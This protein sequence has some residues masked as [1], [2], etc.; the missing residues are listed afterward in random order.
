MAPKRKKLRVVPARKSAPTAD[1]RR[2]VIGAEPEEVLEID[3]EESEEEE[4]VQDIEDQV[5][6]RL[7][8]KSIDAI[9]PKFNIHALETNVYLSQK[10]GMN[11]THGGS[12]HA[13]LRNH[14]GDLV[15]FNEPKN[16]YAKKLIGYVL[17]AFT[18]WA[19]ENGS[20][21][22]PGETLTKRVVCEEWEY[23]CRVMDVPYVKPITRVQT[24]IYNF[25]AGFCNG[26][27]YNHRIRGFACI[28]MEI[29]AGLNKKPLNEMEAFQKSCDILWANEVKQ[30]TRK[31]PDVGW[32]LVL[33]KLL[34][35]HFAQNDLPEIP[36]GTT[37]A[38]AKKARKKQNK[39]DETQWLEGQK[40][41][42]DK[43]PEVVRK[44]KELI[45]EYRETE[46]TAAAAVPRAHQAHLSPQQKAM[47][48]MLGGSQASD[49][50]S[51]PKPGTEEG[52]R[53]KAAKSD[54]DEP[55]A[56]E[57]GG[58][59]PEQDENEE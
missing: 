4:V 5:A 8:Y 15:P 44:Y 40:F 55:Q 2:T 52:D 38:D 47:L 57:E 13:V 18:L 30:H 19:A 39:N 31:E 54:D 37:Q 46:G 36:V 41:I 53:K 29:R 25:L 48:M 9:P 50:D 11:L 26:S 45:E 28:F 17:E 1:G 23:I 33:I 22:P 34:N 10:G 12:M 24:V 20:K 21:V 49:E 3:E 35:G 56:E 51:P 6:L 43:R 14:E 32:F 59:E 42:I 16:H 7:Q 58:S 27:A